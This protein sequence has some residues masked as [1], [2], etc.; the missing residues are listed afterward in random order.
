MQAISSLF[1]LA[2]SIDI[3]AWLMAPNSSRITITIGTLSCMAKSEF[4]APPAIG[5]YSPPAPSI[6]TKL[7]LTSVW[8]ASANWSRANWLPQHLSSHLLGSP[9][10]QSK[11]D[12]PSIEFLLFKT[13]IVKCFSISG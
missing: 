4:K 6:T 9:R 2:A 3:S 5:E 12:I 10:A 7:P 8:H 11:K 1:F 13:S